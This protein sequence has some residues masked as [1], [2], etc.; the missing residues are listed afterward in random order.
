MSSTEDVLEALKTLLATAT[1]AGG[2]LEDVT[3]L[4]NTAIPEAIS[5][6]GLVIIRDGNPGEPERVLGGFDDVYYDHAIDIEVY[7]QD[8]DDADRDEKFAAV[9]SGIGTVLQENR[10]LA[11]TAD[12]IDYGQ[13]SAGIEAVEGFADIK[14]G[15]ITV[16]ASYYASSPLG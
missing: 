14:S 8:A 10:T 3:V 6:A 7:V 1:G 12:G 11:D 15:T 16:T 2:A 9:V 5:E 4:R 13:P